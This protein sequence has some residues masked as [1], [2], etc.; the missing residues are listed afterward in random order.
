MV[1]MMIDMN[2]VLFDMDGTLMDTSR[3]VFRCYNAALEAVGLK[4]EAES[5]LRRCIGPPLEYSF[6]NYFGMDEDIVRRAVS[7]FRVR[8]NDSGVYECEPFPGMIECVRRVKE[9]GYLTAV[10]SSKPEAM[11]TKI[12]KRFDMEEL[13][14]VVAGARPEIGIT[15]K[16]EVLNDLF[17][18]IPKVLPSQMLLI[19]D[20]IFDVEGANLTGIKCLGVEFGFGD[21][22]DMLSAGAVGIVERADQIPEAVDRFFS[23]LAV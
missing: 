7:E 10:A 13:F 12:I 1:K 20:S 6:G 22:N 4:R 17:D 14:D 8:Y 18:R 9:A 3:G 21:T 19:G 15:T 23:G 5:D 2:A 16:E 11:C